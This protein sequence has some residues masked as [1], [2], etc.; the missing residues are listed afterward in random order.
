MYSCVGN[1]AGSIKMD[2]AH[3]LEGGYTGR[4]IILPESA[5]LAGLVLTRDA[6]NPRIVKGISFADQGDD[7]GTY[8]YAVD[9]VTMTPFDGSSTTG[10]GDAG[11]PKFV[12]A[13]AIR[14]PERGAAVSKNVIEPL[15]FGRFVMIVEKEDKVGDGSIEIIGLQSAMRCTDPSTITRQETANGGAWSATLQCSEQF[16]EVVYFNTDYA[17]SHADFEQW[18]HDC[19]L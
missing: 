13:M 3:P 12:K 9:N 11:Y 16:A 15:A 1:L 10:N 6:S 17:T 18:W 7:M 8:G 2:C 19:N 4:A 5:V 14:I